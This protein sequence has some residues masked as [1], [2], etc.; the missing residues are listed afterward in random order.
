MSNHGLGV[1][2]AGNQQIDIAMLVPYNIQCVL[3][4]LLGKVKNAKNRK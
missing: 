3:I 1:D 2:H 4:F